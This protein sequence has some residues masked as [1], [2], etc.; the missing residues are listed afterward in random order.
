ML[1]SQ[2]KAHVCVPSAL[3]ACLHLF[4][5]ARRIPTSTGAMLRLMIEK[6]EILPKQD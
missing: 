5:E 1:L 4:K 6:S 2:P 3:V